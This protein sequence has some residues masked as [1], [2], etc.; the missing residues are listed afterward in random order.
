MDTGSCSKTSNNKFF[1]CPPRMDD[2]RHFTDYRPNCYLNN[3]LKANNKTFNSFQYRM[4]LTHNADK[5]MEMN[6][7]DNCEK[8]CCGP[9]QQ[10]YDQGTM[11]P[12]QEKVSCNRNTCNVT[13]GAKNGLG[14]GRSYTNQPLHCPQWPETLPHGQGQNKCTPA[15]DAFQYYPVD[16]KMAKT[17]RAAVPGGGVQLTGGDP[18]LY[19]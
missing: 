13:A 7:K 19:Q 9:C 1:G 18:N 15:N 12:E 17:P 8:N 4:F 3:T 10:P 5:L 14:Q 2:A 6:R 16:R 11:L